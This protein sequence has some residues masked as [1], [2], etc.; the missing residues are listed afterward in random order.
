MGFIKARLRGG[1]V[2]EDVAYWKQLSK[3]F[4]EIIWFKDIL[5]CTQKKYLFGGS[6]ISE[7]NYYKKQGEFLEF[8]NGIKLI[9]P[10]EKDIRIMKDEF[11]DIVLP[12]YCKKNMS[13][14]K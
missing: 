8:K 2:Y 14:H 13:F 5:R 6:H 12:S 7:S 3:S 10:D 9:I 4:P 1:N 11:I